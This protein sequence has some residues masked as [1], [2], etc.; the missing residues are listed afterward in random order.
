MS[1]SGISSQTSMMV[2]SLVDMRRQLDDLQR[3]LGTGQ[4]SNTYA[5]HGHRPRPCSRT[6]LAACWARADF[7]NAISNV[8]VR[9]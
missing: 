6:A 4:K 1:I 9:H 8:G 3:Q 5:G 7:D 2:Q